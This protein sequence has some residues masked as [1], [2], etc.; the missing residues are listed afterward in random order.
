MGPQERQE[1]IEQFAEA[2]SSRMKD[3]S[4]SIFKKDWWSG[5]MLEWCMQNESFKV[6]MFRFIDVL[7]YLNS[8][9]EVARHIKE[10]FLRQGQNFPAA[11]STVLGFAAG[12]GFTA[13]IAPGGI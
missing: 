4:V 5:R 13:K 10:Y 1:I 6:E 9:E 8:S 3:E 12:S 7:P 2:V 11:V